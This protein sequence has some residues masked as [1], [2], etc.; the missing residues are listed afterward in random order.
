VGL[1]PAAGRRVG[2]YSTGMPQT[3]TVALAVT[4]AWL[5][6]RGGALD[7]GSDVVTTTI[8]GAV[9]WDTAFAAIGVSV[10]AIAPNLTV[11][12]VAGLAWIALVEA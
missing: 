11:A 5:T 8:V 1:T 10:G 6:A 2:G 3:A 4:A 7:L 12:I 9:L